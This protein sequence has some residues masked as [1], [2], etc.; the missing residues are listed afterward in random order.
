MKGGDSLPLLSPLPFPLINSYHLGRGKRVMNKIKEVPEGQKPDPR[1][2][3]QI[4]KRFEWA[5]TFLIVRYGFVHQV[6]SMMT[7]SPSLLVP[8]MGVYVRSGARFEL[9]Y[10]PCFVEALS[11]EE[12]VYVFYH[13]VMHVVLHH[14]TSRKFP[15]KS[16]GNIADDLAVNELIPINPGSCEIPTLNGKPVGAFVRTY[17]KDDPNIREKQTAEWY[18]SFLM[19]KAKQQ[20]GCGSEND[21]KDKKP[22]E[23]NQIDTHDG[24]KE[25]EVA[26]ERIRAKIK[27]IDRSNTWGDLSESSKE[28]IRAAQIRRINWRNLI[29][30]FLG[31][32]A[33][34]AKEYT[35]KRPNRRMG[36]I[37]AGSKRLF[38]DKTLVAVDT[39]GSVNPDLLSK[40]LA[41]VNGMLDFMPIDMM[42]F[43]ADKT[44]G[45]VSF[46]KRKVDY[47]F[48]GRGGTNFEP[49]MQVVK[50][51]RYRSVIIL[52][53]GC[54]PAPS[55][56]HADVLW[57]LPPGYVPPV[58]WGKRIH[59]DH[60][61]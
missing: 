46:D 8:T 26:A 61:D 52:T 11:D 51:K 42:Q 50:E 31:N 2:L 4:K 23:G 15:D 41:V 45:P 43:D 18:Y 53:D 48:K 1:F 44:E 16:L 49:I 38:V 28:L 7:K 9:L 32:H 35:R 34:S 56:P 47:T 10:N 14:C 22:G 37:Y 33:W 21:S 20:N 29:R 60:S 19:E 24:W 5:L 59:M 40:F 39:S 25:D 6:L 57:V 17:Q 54:A 13:E 12:L 30:R 36:Y 27:E 3:A 55:K 58:D